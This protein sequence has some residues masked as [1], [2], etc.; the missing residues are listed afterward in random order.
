MKELFVRI[1]LVVFAAATLL[2]M[3]GCFSIDLE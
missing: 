1:V 3:S 2:T